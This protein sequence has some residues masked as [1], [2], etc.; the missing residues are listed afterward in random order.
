MRVVRSAEVEL[1]KLKKLIRN[2]AEYYFKPVTENQIEMYAE[3][4][5]PMGSKLAEQASR[6]YRQGFGNIDFPIPAILKQQVGFFE[7]TLLKTG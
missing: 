5:L 3:D 1:P 2:L 6:E 4:L 7:N